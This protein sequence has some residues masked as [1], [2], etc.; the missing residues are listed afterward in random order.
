MLGD[1][2]EHSGAEIFDLIEAARKAAFAIR[3]SEI[4]QD[5]LAK[6]FGERR[7]ADSCRWSGHSSLFALLANLGEDQH[8]E[9]R[10]AIH[11]RAARRAPAEQPGGDL[12]GSFAADLTDARAG[13]RRTGECHRRAGDPPPTR[14]GHRAPS[15]DAQN[16]ITE[17]MRL[18]RRTELT[19]AE[20]QAAID[21]IG[22]QI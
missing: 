5:D 20:E 17:L 21:A 22:R 19:P 4:D 12:R 11:E 1:V 15:F 16:R 6:L 13:R 10:R 14:K 3:R 2:R 9:R 8:R 18:R 7:P